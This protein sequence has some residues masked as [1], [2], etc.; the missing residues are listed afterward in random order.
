MPWMVPSSPH[1]P[2]SSGKTTSTSPRVRGGWDGSVHDEV[3]RVAVLGERDR[4]AVA[5]DAGSWSGPSI[6]SRSGSPDSSTQRP[7]VAM[8]TGTTSYASRSMACSTLPAVTHEIAC[9]LERPPKTTATRGLRVGAFIGST[10]STYARAHARG[11]ARPEA[12]HRRGHRRSPG[13]AA[14]RAAEH[15]AHDGVDV[16]RRRRPGVRPLRQPHLDGVRG[17]PR[18]ARGRALPVVRVRPGRRRHGARPGRPGQP[19]WSRRGT[20]T[21]AP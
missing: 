1:G 12:R 8:P 21:T 2:C 6:R 13:H 20:P 9:S 19:W 10:L 7:S 4:R 14:G 18:R 11:R 3:G 15:A 5:V 16:R 17:G